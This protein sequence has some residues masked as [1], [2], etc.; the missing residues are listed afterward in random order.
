MLAWDEEITNSRF[1]FEIVKFLV[2]NKVSKK[3][4]K[5]A[6]SRFILVTEKRKVSD[7][8]EKISNL[9]RQCSYW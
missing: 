4:K 7:T 8:K 1:S 5:W 9:P 6:S 2:P 3:S